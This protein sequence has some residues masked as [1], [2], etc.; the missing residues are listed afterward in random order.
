MVVQ[1]PNADNRRSVKVRGYR[2]ERVRVS[3]KFG[4]L[5]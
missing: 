5:D 2:H 1:Y 3:G 4:L